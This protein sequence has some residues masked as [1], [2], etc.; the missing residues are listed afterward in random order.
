MKSQRVG[1]HIQAK[2]SSRPLL[3]SKSFTG[4]DLSQQKQKMVLAFQVAL[5]VKNPPANAGD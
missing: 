5:V 2:E 3:M 4:L 1:E